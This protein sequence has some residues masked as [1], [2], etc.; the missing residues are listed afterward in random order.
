MPATR[1][2]CLLWPNYPEAVFSGIQSPLTQK[3]IHGN[4]FAFSIIKLWYPVD[5]PGGE[6]PNL[7]VTTAI[8]NFDLV[9]SPC[10]CVKN[11]KEMR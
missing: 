7:V 9:I 11:S 3:N 2:V 5:P 1:S 4:V 6:S 8:L 10:C